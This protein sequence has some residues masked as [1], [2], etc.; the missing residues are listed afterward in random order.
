MS[1]YFVTVTLT[2]CEEVDADSKE[3]AEDIVSNMD[4]SNIPKDI[5]IEAED[6]EDID[7]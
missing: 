4:W 2:F 3:A 7:V 1:K 6:V 5:D